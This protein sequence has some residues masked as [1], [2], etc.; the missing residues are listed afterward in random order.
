[1]SVGVAWFPD[2]GHIMAGIFVFS[3]YTEQRENTTL[4]GDG[5]SM[6][7]LIPPLEGT[8]LSWVLRPLDSGIWPLLPQPPNLP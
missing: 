7:D 3:N 6:S 1:M 2:Y 4:I 5:P 8:T